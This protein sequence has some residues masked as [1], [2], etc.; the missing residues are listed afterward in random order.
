MGVTADGKNY[1]YQGQLI[2]IFL[3]IRANQS[4]YTLDV[5]PAGTVNVKIIRNADD[6]I[7]G[8]VYMTEEEVTGLFGE[9]DLDE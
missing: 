8:A 2:H 6:E 1:Y 5:N 9:G 4:F 3:D 7:T